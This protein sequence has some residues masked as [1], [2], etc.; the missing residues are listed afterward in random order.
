VRG[1]YRMKY[2]RKYE[3]KCMGANVQSVDQRSATAQ[4]KNKSCIPHPHLAASAL[5]KDV[6]RHT[7]TW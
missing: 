6:L 4:T 3:R 2:E 5:S 1:V 7:S